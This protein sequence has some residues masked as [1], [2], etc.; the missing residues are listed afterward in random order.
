MKS[1]NYWLL[2]ITVFAALACARE[3]DVAA[4][5]MQVK[6]AWVRAVP[7]VS[8]NSAGYLVV[9]NGSNRDDALLGA[10]V[11]KAR[12]TELHEM[13]REGDTMFMQ[14]RKEI[15]VPAHGRAMLA[16][17]GLHLMLIDLQQPLQVGEK[18]DGVLH[19]RDAGEVKIQ[20]E[21]RQH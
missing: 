21:V 11:N 18:L 6:D 3:P 2:L 5:A 13:V 15:P 19:F 4:S 17:G 7:P 12:V 20:L 16:P 1:K 9:E 8:K 14:R 10:S